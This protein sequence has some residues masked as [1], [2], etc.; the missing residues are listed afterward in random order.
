MCFARAGLNASWEEVTSSGMPLAT[1]LA[2]PHPLSASFLPEPRVA[3]PRLKQETSESAEC[4]KTVHASPRKKPRGLPETYKGEK[5]LPCL[6]WTGAACRM[7]EG[8]LAA[9]ALMRPLSRLTADPSGW[10]TSWQK[11]RKGDRAGL[12]VSFPPPSHG[13]I[14]SAGRFILFL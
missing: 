13:D 5:E 3:D 12:L 2:L 1:L 6:Q 4:S 9:A 10:P 7:L 8:S 11:E 14:L